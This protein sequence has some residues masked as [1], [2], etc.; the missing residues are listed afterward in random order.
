MYRMSSYSFFVLVVTLCQL[1]VNIL[2]Y[3]VTDN[4]YTL[5]RS[6][7]SIILFTCKFSTTLRVK[8]DIPTVF[9]VTTNSV[10]QSLHMSLSSRVTNGDEVHV[11]PCP[12]YLPL[13]R[14][15]ISFV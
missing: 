15:N 1:S 10:P 8:M 5:R 9:R 12:G 7:L 2:S 4:L 14:Y 6:G 11:S 3:M 13:N